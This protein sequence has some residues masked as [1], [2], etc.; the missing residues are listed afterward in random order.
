MKQGEFKTRVIWC[1]D[2]AMEVAV[3]FAVKGTLLRREVEVADCPAMHEPGRRCARQCVEWVGAG[4]AARA[5][6]G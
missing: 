5:W 1:R 3:T 4:T 6:S 2:R